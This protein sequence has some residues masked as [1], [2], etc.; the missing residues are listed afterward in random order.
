MDFGENTVVLQSPAVTRLLTVIRDRET[1]ASQ[2]IQYSNR[3]FR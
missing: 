1:H 2:F 3:L